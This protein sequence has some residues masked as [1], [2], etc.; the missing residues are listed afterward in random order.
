MPQRDAAAMPRAPCPPRQPRWTLRGGGSAAL[1]GVPALPGW[2]GGRSEELQEV[3][4]LLG[5]L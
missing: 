3:H 2:H 4:L 5:T 1:A